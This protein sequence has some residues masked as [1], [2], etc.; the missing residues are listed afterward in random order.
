VGIFVM[1]SI[2]IGGLI[3]FTLGSETNL[4]ASK[5]TYSVLFDDASGLR[6][7]S[8]VHVAGVPVGSVQS[9]E[10]TKEG[11]IRVR[12]EVLSSTARLIRGIPGGPHPDDIP[13]GEP[14]GS[15]A[16]IQS[17]GMLGDMLLSVSVGDPSFPEWPTDKSL[18]VARGGSLMDM[19]TEAMEEVQGTA[20]NLRRA[21]EPLANEQFSEDVQATAHNLAS[22]TG[23]LAEGDGTLQR[24][25]TDEELSREVDAA[26]K[27]FRKASSELEGL[28]GSLRRIAHEVERGNGGLH[29]II[30]GDT[31]A[32]AL[33]NI[34]RAADEVALALAAIRE[35]DGTAHQLVYGNAADDMLA[36]LTR[37]TDDIAAI[38]RHIRAGRGTIGG[39]LIDPSIYED[40]KR[41]V[42]DLERN[43]ILRALV[44]YGI[45]RDEGAERPPE[46][47]T[48]EE[49]EPVDDGLAPEADAEER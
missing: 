43:R 9:V 49:V 19:A 14:R 44:R 42:G 31:A 27:D 47:A 32:D 12:I 48:L 18:P 33:D 34:G 22:V 38:T 29:Q 37:A 20:R 6:P 13:P 21:T 30:Y 2:A 15:T 35:G 24:L 8:P 5:A 23:M 39:L 41:I 10:F 11:R 25:M 45:R 4:F 1:T 17:K 3:A 46:P 7:G 40:V 16:S 26:I 36:N 28:S